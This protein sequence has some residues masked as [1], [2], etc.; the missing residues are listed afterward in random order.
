M[1]SRAPLACPETPTE[2]GFREPRI[3]WGRKPD[4]GCPATTTFEDQNMTTLHDKLRSRG[5]GL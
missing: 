2:I 4:F 5:I 1:Q 3:C